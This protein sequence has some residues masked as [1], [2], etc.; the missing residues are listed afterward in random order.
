M[1]LVSQTTNR[2]NRM[3]RNKR[4]FVY[5]ADS[6]V[7]ISCRICKKELMEISYKEV[8]K[9]DNTMRVYCEICDD[10]RSDN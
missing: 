6:L 9:L 3:T 1:S 8:N 2:V 7:R 4:K 10:M 5:T